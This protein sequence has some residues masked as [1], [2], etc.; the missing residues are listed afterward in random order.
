M[1]TSTPSIRGLM[2]LTSLLLLLTHPG[3]AQQRTALPASSTIRH[4]TWLMFLSD[5]R[6]S[7]R[8][9]LHTEVQV[10]RTRTSELGSQNVFR[11]GANYYAA[12]NLVLT[13]GYAYSQA[14]ADDNFTGAI[15][16]E[17][18]LYQQVQLHDAKS[19]LH[20]HH[21]YR[22]EQRWVQF[23][24]GQEFAYLNRMRYQLRLVV[25]LLG[26]ELTSRMPYAV[27]ADEIFLGFGKGSKGRLFQQNRAYLGVGYQISKASAVELGYLN[28]FVQLPVES[29]PELNENIQF[30]LC[31][32]PD[33]RRTMPSLK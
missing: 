13:G 16:P 15:G 8:W 14:V 23:Q 26:P 30:S 22:L 3:T 7:K 28:Q 10:L 29:R 25:P 5:A 20:V 21:R 31:F 11:G 27:A 24:P 2:L 17:H 33:W 32:N 18:R 4:N 12:D 9:G 1:Q 19:R 6:L